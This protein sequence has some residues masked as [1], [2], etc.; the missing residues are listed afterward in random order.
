MAQTN[1]GSGPKVIVVGGGVMGVATACA[2]AGRGAQV[3]LL[4]RFSVGHAW[5]S[6]HGMTRAIR[7][8]YGPQAIYTRM[9]ARSLLLWD[10]LAH[11]TGRHLYTETGV[12]TLGHADDGHTLPGYEVMRA[13]GLPVARLTAQ[14]CRVR[15]P[16]FTPDEYDAITWNPHGGML[17]ASECVQALADRLRARGGTLR[18]GARVA[19]VEPTGASG[20]RVTLENGMT[21]DA[22][23]VVVTAGPWVRDVLPDLALPVRATRQQVSYFLGASPDRFGVGAFPVFLAEMEC[24]GF[25]LQGPGW[26]KVASHVIGAEVNP[27]IPY[28][29]DAEE[30]AYVRDFMRRVLP[31][32]A[33]SELALVDRCMYDMTPDED[34]ILDRHPGGA[35]VVIGSGFS[36]HGFKFGALI[37]ELLAALAL[38]ETPEFP[39]DQF[40]LSR[41]GL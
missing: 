17:F 33:D 9:V 25:P 11:E 23:R 2:L 22:D 31:E 13:E 34:F 26:L 35:G 38:D 36:G 1:G 37:G 6:S 10:A 20:G 30:V 18:E 15:F 4:E 5:A 41:F 12:L 21:L 19:R 7:H 32:V 8:E 16:Q 39:L 28:A 40:R 24:Y 29:P 14:E 3:A 27:N